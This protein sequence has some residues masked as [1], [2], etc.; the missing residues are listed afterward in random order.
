MTLKQLA[1]KD[2]HKVWAQA[3]MPTGEADAHKVVEQ[4]FDDLEKD[5]KK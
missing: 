1:D 3:D 5:L 4:L 2:S